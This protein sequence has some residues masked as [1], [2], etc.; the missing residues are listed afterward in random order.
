[1][2]PDKL[3]V[4][5]HNDRGCAENFKALDPRFLWMKKEKKYKEASYIGWKPL[6]EENEKMGVEIVMKGGSGGAK[7]EPLELTA[8]VASRW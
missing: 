2:V 4:S 6:G 8:M 5:K 1:M 7:E 3:M